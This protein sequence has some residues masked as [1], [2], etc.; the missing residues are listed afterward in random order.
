MG[1]AGCGT[2]R[3]RL[4]FQIYGY[5]PTSPERFHSRFG[6]DLATFGTTWYLRTE[7]GPAWIEAD[8]VGWSVRVGGP[9]WETWTDYRIV[10]LDDLIAQKHSQPLGTRLVQGYLGLLDFVLDRALSR[11][12]RLRWP[13]AVFTLYPLVITALAALVGGFIGWTIS[14]VAE[15]L[16]GGI[17]G[18]LAFV[19]LFILSSRKFYLLALLEDWAFASILVRRLEPEIDHRLDRACDEIAARVAGATAD[20]VLLIGH[21]LGAVLVLHLAAKLIAVRVPMSRVAVLTLGSSLLKIGLHGAA[22]DTRAATRAVA[23]APDPVWA[24]YQSVLDIMNFPGIEPVAAMGVPAP[25]PP[26]V[27]TAPFSRMLDPAAY[28]RLRFNFFRTH[29]QFVHAGTRRCAYDYFMFAC[30]PFAFADLATARD[31]AVPRIG[32]NGALCGTGPDLA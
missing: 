28:R 5:Q 27:R 3:N 22:H 26:I 19:A 24:D 20:E 4:V 31:G 18:G 9:G 12:L 16:A 1:D 15:A 6:R 13:Y 14:R 30:G 17:A 8:A 25:H 32:D 23:A 21:S 29:N 11:Y 7:L 10:R 2:I